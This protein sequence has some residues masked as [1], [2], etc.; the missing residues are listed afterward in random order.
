MLKR[1]LNLAI[2]SLFGAFDAVRNLGVRLV[3]IKPASR[4]V[5]LAYHSVTAG[6]REEFAHQMDVLLKTAKAVPADL[7]I[8]P[9]DGAAYAAVTF[10]DGFQNVV[11]N[12]LPELQQR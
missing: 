12:A 2:S 6:E 9:A 11:D 4:C 7:A 1:I 8:L 3:G 10:D 5:V